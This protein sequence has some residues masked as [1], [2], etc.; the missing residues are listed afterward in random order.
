MKELN[1]GNKDSKKPFWRS[2]LQRSQS[3]EVR[4]RSVP[5]RSKWRGECRVTQHH[6]FGSL[7]G[8]HLYILGMRSHLCSEIIA[9]S[10]VS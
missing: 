1:Q 9:I 10:V 4:Y 7:Y 2:N 6:D 8:L 5:K 3:C